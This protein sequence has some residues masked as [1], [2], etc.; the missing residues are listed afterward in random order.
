M[1]PKSSSHDRPG[2]RLQALLGRHQPPVR[3]VQLAHDLGVS[4]TTIVRYLRA[5]DDGTLDERVWGQVAR[6][7]ADK[8]QIDVTEIRP[9][10]ATL[11]VDASLVPYL[12]GFDG[13][14]LE[15]L[16]KILEGSHQQAARDLLLVV[17][18]DRLLRR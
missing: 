10:R 1:K 13:T 8:Y 17:A 3:Q 18:R 6:M 4:A 11:S 15:A 7:L 9:V 12:D 5:L 16:V 2:S 14:Q